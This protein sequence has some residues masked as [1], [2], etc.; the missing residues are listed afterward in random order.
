VEAVHE[1]AVRTDQTRA[2][3]ALFGLGDQASGSE[4]ISYRDATDR[5]GQLQ[6]AAEAMTALRRAAT[7]GDGQLAAAIARHARTRGWAEVAGT[8]IEDAGPAGRR[9]LDDLAEA[10]STAAYWDSGQGRFAA[11]AI[12]HIEPPRELAG[13][14]D[15]QIEQTA[16]RRTG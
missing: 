6:D 1:H 12:F 7:S 8:W 9:H 3:R 11:S 16:A 2:G 5:A 15:T 4:V 14:N 10:D 13:L